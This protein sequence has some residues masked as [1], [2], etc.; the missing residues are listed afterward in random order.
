MANEVGMK[1]WVESTHLNFRVLSII[2]PINKEGNVPASSSINPMFPAS[3]V[4]PC[5]RISVELNLNYLYTHND[6]S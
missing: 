3:T 1:S 6:K 5:I 4:R 2:F